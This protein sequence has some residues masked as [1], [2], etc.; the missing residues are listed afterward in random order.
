MLVGA[1]FGA[2]TR[3]KFRGF[4]TYSQNLW[5]VLWMD[6]PWHLFFLPAARIPT[7]AQKTGINK[8]INFYNGL[9]VFCEVWPDVDRPTS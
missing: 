3:R 9:A 4:V 2:R 5:I 8:Y 7:T 1:A 6:P